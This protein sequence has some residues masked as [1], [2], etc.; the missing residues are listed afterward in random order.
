MGRAGFGKRKDMVNA[1]FSDSV[2]GAQ[3]ST[4]V[5]ARIVV[6]APSA[7]ADGFS[8]KLCGN[9]SSLADSGN[10]A[11][12]AIAPRPRRSPR[13]STILLVSVIAVF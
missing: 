2:H 3:D 10:A 5:G 7:K 4:T 12:A 8:D 6:N 11:E 13:R 1:S 9:L